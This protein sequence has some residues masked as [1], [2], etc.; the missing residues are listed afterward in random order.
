MTEVSA[1]NNIG[2]FVIP[3]VVSS[4]F[5]IRNGD[6]VADIGAG[7]GYFLETL[8]SLVG[9]EGKLYAVDVQ[10]N[11]VE[12]MGDLARTK[13]LNN[14]EVIWGDCDEANGSKIPT[15]VVDVAILVNT[16]FQFEKKD[17]AMQELKRI[18]RPGGKLFIIDW[19][20][21]FSGLGPQPEQVITDTVA[22]DFAAQAG[23]T[24]EHDFDA[25]D[26]HYGLAFRL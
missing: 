23:F 26:H 19:S 14:V 5:H 8:S 6:T 1:L 4:H 10:K 9:Q 18:L 21:S 3:S 7:T 15:D 13:N 2:R 25:G 24:F 16:L 20:E 11:L 22:K 17:D 12:A